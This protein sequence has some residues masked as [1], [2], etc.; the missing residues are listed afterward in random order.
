MPKVSMDYSRTIIYKLVCKDL[1]ITDLYIGHTTN[2]IKRRYGHK[3]SCNNENDKNYN[4]FVYQTIRD[5][6]GW[7]NWDMIEVE[8]YNCNDVNEALKQERYWIETLK[9][10]LNK[11]LPLRTQTEWYL[12][13]KEEIIERTKQHYTDNKEQVLKYHKDYYLQ[14]KEK[15]NEKQ[16]EYRLVNKENLAEYHKKYQLNNNEKI[17]ERKNKKTICECGGCYSY[18]DKSKHF[19]SI[20]HSNYLL[21]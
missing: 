6:G 16:K 10:T 19:K 17:K 5:T 12:E 13:H 18:G 11:V 21:L 4:L 7:N 1:L 20:K 3:T 15:I 8:K 2:F 9:A 14:N